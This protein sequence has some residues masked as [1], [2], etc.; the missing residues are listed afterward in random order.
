MAQTPSSDTH[1]Q[2]QRSNENFSHT[3]SSCE[4]SC[5][6]DLRLSSPFSSSHSEHGHPAYP[7]KTT[8]MVISLV[9][10]TYPESYMR[11]PL[12]QPLRFDTNHNDGT[13]DMMLP[14]YKG[15]D[16]GAEADVIQSIEHED[17]NWSSSTPQSETY[18]RTNRKRRSS[19]SSNSRSK[20]HKT[21]P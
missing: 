21:S 16:P 9:D 3:T 5:E 10:I 12:P 1:S 7:A 11:T 4:S 14:I 18:Q 2:P 15:N 19:T 20:K 13:N 8:P 6:D 17:K